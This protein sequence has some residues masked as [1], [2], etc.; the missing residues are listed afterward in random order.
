MNQEIEIGGTTA[1]FVKGFTDCSNLVQAQAEAAANLPKALPD[2]VDPPIDSVLHSVNFVVSYGAGISPSWSLLQ[3][4]GPGAGGTPLLS[5]SGQR[6]H[7]LNLSLGP[8]SGGPAISGDALRLIN[9]QTIR[10]IGV[11]PGG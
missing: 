4:K 11:V 2:Q 9:N 8:R 1:D 6:T 10:N 5:A 3:W 7:T